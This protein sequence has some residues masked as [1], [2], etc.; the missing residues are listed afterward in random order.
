VSCFEVF[1]EYQFVSAFLYFSLIFGFILTIWYYSEKW[2]REKGN[3]K[4]LKAFGIS[5]PILVYINSTYVTYY[6][7]PDASVV[8]NLLLSFMI[9]F[10]IYLL[11]RHFH[12]SDNLIKVIVTVLYFFIYLV[13]LQVYWELREQCNL[14]R[15]LLLF[16]LIYISQYIITLK[17]LTLQRKINETDNLAVS[18]NS[19]HN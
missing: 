13:P 15:T 17:I 19:L 3:T 8:W 5:L 10:G 4:L 9:W 16:T 2:K 6:L 14:T 1:H 7:T 11:L 18:H 12:I